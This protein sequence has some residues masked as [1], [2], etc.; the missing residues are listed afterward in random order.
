MSVI[1]VCTRLPG[2]AILSWIHPLSG[3]GLGSKV[4]GFKRGE[5]ERERCGFSRN[6][7]WNSWRRESDGPGIRG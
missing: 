3:K 6:S 2:R 5:V 1:K 4:A 7:R